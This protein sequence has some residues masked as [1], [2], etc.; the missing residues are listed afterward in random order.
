M[1]V[2]LLQ[3]QHSKK[4]G[5][6]KVCKAI[7]TAEVKCITKN[8]RLIE[9]TMK[10]QE[11]IDSKEILEI[12]KTLLAQ[13]IILEFFETAEKNDGASFRILE[14]DQN[15]VNKILE[16]NYQ[17]CVI[18]QRKI[19]KLTIVGFGITQD[20]TVLN[21]IVNILLKYNIEVEKIN[22]TQ[23]KIE[24]LLDQIDASIVE[25]IHKELI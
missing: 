14:S 24:I 16:E 8:D 2:K 10:K 12:Y 6:T 11:K 25:E 19:V 9:I 4:N 21:K 1:D 17:E 20:N 7:E 3:N 15:K 5:E 13:N 23:A 22:L 18:N